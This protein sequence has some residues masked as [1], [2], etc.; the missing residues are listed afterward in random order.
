MKRILSIS[1]LVLSAELLAQNE[2]PTGTIL[3]VALNSSLNLQKSSRGSICFSKTAKRR[4]LQRM[5]EAALRRIREGTQGICTAC[6]DDIQRRRLEAL[7]WTRISST[8]S[9]AS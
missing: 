8:L 1:L 7:P 5:T 3:P 2:I 4:G 9:G 6:R